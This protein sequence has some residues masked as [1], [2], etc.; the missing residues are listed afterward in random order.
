VA[1]CVVAECVVAVTVVVTV[2]A[3]AGGELDAAGASEG[4]RGT[5]AGA[6]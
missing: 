6:E 2:V 4:D 5:D 3:D 1:E